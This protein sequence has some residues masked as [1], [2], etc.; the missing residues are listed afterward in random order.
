MNTA[1]TITLGILHRLGQGAAESPDRDLIRTW[2]VLCR[3]PTVYF[4]LL[5]QRYLRG[6]SFAEIARTHKYPEVAI[7]HWHDRAVHAYAI[8][9][10][11]AGLITPPV[12]SS[13]RRST[14]KTTAADIRQDEMFSEDQF[15][16]VAVGSPIVDIHTALLSKR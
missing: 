4:C 14:S 16:A 5:T 15:D 7:R 11:G 1:Q 10:Q 8:A 6:F 3:L 2:D 9:L 12:P 13:G